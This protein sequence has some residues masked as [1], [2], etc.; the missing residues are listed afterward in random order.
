VSLSRRRCHRHYDV[1]GG[2][3]VPFVILQGRNHDLGFPG[4]HE[5]GKLDFI[6][7]S[8][9]RHKEGTIRNSTPKD[10]S[11]FIWLIEALPNH[12]NDVAFTDLKVVK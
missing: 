11:S 2:C 9:N 1:F 4:I 10:A 6:T 7:A 5:K 12:G 3:Q 8:C